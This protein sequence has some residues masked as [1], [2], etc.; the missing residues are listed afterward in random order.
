[1]YGYYPDVLII[2]EAMYKQGI[3]VEI[4]PFDRVMGILREDD[5]VG[6]VPYPDKYMD[7]GGTSNQIRLP[8]VEDDVT[9]EKLAELISLTEWDPE[10]QVKPL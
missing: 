7:R 1:M 6:I 2:A 9:E 10:E 5:L 3:C 8:Y 4:S